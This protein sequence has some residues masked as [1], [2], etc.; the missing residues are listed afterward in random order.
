M[1]NDAK[2]PM[3]QKDTGK[4]VEIE[5]VVTLP[6]QEEMMARLLEVDR[7]AS[8]KEGLYPLLLE[9]LAGKTLPHGEVMMTL[10]LAIEAFAEKERILSYRTHDM[11]PA[12]IDALVV[13]PKVATELKVQY[14]DM[15]EGMDRLED[16][17]KKL[18]EK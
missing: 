10:I 9:H 8:T 5:S 6:N 11:A 2:P 15:L 18:S 12:F 7:R 16:L 1:R 13:D 3:R 17:L 4:S 14:P